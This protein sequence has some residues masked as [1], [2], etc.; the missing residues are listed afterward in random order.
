MIHQRNFVHHIFAN[1]LG[2]RPHFFKIVL[3]PMGIPHIPISGKILI[4]AYG[5][6]ADKGEAKEVRDGEGGPK[7]EHGE[8]KIL[9]SGINRD[10]LKKSGQDPCGVCQTG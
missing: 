7:C 5:G 1:G 4:G 10:L 2:I 8:T 3:F 9:E 6:T